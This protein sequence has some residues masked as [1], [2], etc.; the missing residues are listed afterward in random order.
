M[1]AIKGGRLKSL[2]DSATLSKKELTKL[3]K[4]AERRTSDRAKLKESA[5]N[6][7]PNTRRAKVQ[8]RRVAEKNIPKPVRDMMVSPK[9]DAQNKADAKLRS[10]DK[11]NKGVSKSAVEKMI[12]EATDKGRSVIKGASTLAKL[13]RIGTGI[14]AFLSADEVGAGS[15]KISA[16]QKDAFVKRMDAERKKREAELK[17]KG[18]SSADRKGSNAYTPR[19]KTTAK[20]TG[21][22]AGSDRQL[23][24]KA[25]SRK[26]TG[27]E[28]Y[29]H[30]KSAGGVSFGEAFK[31]WKGKGSKTF[32]W[33]G[34]KYSTKVA[35]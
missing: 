4:D 10:D 18:S 6:A 1:A 2:T 12:K 3:E 9:Q 5:K 7:P 33:N 30:G 22:T 21:S 32:T 16:G 35:K 26:K 15:D 11:R 20:P 8:S 19:S 27:E 17:K 13:A 25:E 28:K 23:I 14:G 34:K 31:Y 24:K 29:K